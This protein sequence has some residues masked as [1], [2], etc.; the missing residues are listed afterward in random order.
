MKLKEGER[1]KAETRKNKTE[2]GKRKR[3]KERGA[4]ARS[5]KRGERGT[6]T[7]PHRKGQDQPTTKLREVFSYVWGLLD[8]I[9]VEV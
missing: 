4:L 1:R 5:V 2:F 3:E 7:E 9:W 8:G 6:R